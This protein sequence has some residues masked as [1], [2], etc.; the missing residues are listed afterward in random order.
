M[1]L[2]KIAIALCA[3]LSLSACSGT[4]HGVKADAKDMNN[5]VE[6]KPSAIGNS[7]GAF[8]T[9]YTGQNLGKPVLHPPARGTA[10]I[11]P[12]QEQWHQA[13][14]MNGA[15]AQGSAALEATASAPTNVNNDVT[16]YP[17]DGPAASS[18]SY[19]SNNMPAV[20]DYG[21]LVQELYFGYGSARVSASDAKKL[22][23]LGKD[24]ASGKKDAVHVTVVGHASKKVKGVKDPVRRKEINFEMAQKRADAVTR[25]LKKSGISPAWVESVSKGDEEPNANTGGKSQDA[26]D[27]RVDVY[28]K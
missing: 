5:W 15:P 2:T 23:A 25:V 28:T 4:W 14:D 19:S 9:G 17:I 22:A 20:Q 7:W 3:A 21:Q 10:D 1:R 6:Q 24:I 26:A 12:S 18:V 13:G 16:V 8:P 27:Q 11:S